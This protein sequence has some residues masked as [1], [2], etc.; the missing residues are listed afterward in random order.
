MD[1]QKRLTDEIGSSN[2]NHYY[3]LIN[4]F[5][6]FHS[7]WLV[8]K[9]VWT[10][11][12]I[13]FKDI[14]INVNL[15]CSKKLHRKNLGLVMIR[16]NLQILENEKLI[17]SSRISNGKG[18]IKIYELTEKGELNLYRFEELYSKYNGKQ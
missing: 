8:L 2:N 18:K 10:S 11:K 1:K 17:T 15:I 4:R 9:M 3:N 12:K 14:E 5:D 6:R 16:Y 13:N 7:I